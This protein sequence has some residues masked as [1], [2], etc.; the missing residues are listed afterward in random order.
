[1]A[2]KPAPLGWRR[3]AM[4]R[5]PPP[6]A[7]SARTACQVGG[8]RPGASVTTMDLDMVRGPRAPRS[9]AMAATGPL[10]RSSQAATHP[11]ALGAGQGCAGDDERVGG[12]QL[13]AQGRGQGVGVVQVNHHVVRQVGVGAQPVHPIFAQH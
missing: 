12:Q 13:V 2:S 4:R 3:A 1:M 10:S 8:P 9:A 11:R 6:N 5:R 7:V